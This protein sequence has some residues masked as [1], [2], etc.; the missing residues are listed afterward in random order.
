MNILN[1]LREANTVSVIFR[2]VIAMILG[3]SIGLTRNRKGKPAGYR[4]ASSGQRSC[5]TEGYINRREKYEILKSA[6]TYDIF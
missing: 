4:N 5:F 1:Y 2:L 3:G 6:Y